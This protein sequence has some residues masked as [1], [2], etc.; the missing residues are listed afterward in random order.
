MT[1]WSDLFHTRHLLSRTFYHL[2]GS[3]TITAPA[4][5]AFIRASAVGAGGWRTGQWGHGAAFARVKQVASPGAQYVVQVGN[6]ANSLD[7]GSSL[8]D[9][10]VQK[11]SGSVTILLA[12]R[13]LST[14]PGLAANCTGDVTRTG[15]A[16]AGGQQAGGSAGDD[17]DPFPLGFGGRG[18]MVTLA[19]APGGGGGK[20]IIAIPGY[21]NTWT[22]PGG[23]GRVCVEFFDQDPGY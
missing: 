7:G 9:S 16:W 8:G 10:F 13:G 17:A 20:N 12:Q 1:L 3:Q 11:V 5:T 21:G 18:G 14:S 6:Q 2:P 4:G 19:P 22:V 23:S 15:T